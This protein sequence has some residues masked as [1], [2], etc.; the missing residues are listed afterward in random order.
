MVL[1]FDSDTA[2]QAA[3]VRVLDNL[4]ASGL[5]IRV[6]TMPAPH[7]PDSFI[8]GARRRGIPKLIADAEDSSTSTSITSARR[9]MSVPTKARWP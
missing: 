7:D 3:A 2:G 6:A 4:L 9:T 1:C 5:A 8:Q